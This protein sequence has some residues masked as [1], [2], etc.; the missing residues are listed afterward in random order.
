MRPFK[1]WSRGEKNNLQVVMGT[2]I[3]HLGQRMSK[4]GMHQAIVKN[5]VLDSSPRGSSL[6]GGGFGWETCIKFLRES[7][8]GSLSYTIIRNSPGMFSGYQ[9]YDG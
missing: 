1:V 8:A 5:A 9:Y 4:L 3:Q 6:G 2:V 7:E